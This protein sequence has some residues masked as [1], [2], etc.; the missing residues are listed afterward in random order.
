MT[1][2]YSAKKTN[3][4]SEGEKKDNNRTQRDRI[5]EEVLG[6]VVVFLLTLNVT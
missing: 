2:H 1:D 6:A 4:Q 5:I 3:G